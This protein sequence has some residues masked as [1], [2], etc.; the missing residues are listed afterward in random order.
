MT[1]DV[2]EITRLAEFV[3]SICEEL[4]VDMS[5]SFNIDLALE[6]AVSNVINYAYGEQTGCPVT[7]Y[8]SG[9][10]DVI[11]FTL[12]DEGVPFN[13]LESA[14]EVDVTLSAE[15]REI[16]GLGIFL[17][18]NIMQS[19]EYRREDNRNVLMMTYRK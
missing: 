17:I 18:Q 15:E 9:E 5:A 2:S 13:P 19:V 16:G 3:E 10:E 12:V 4:E 6:E 14:P 11:V 7:L 8:V 1:N